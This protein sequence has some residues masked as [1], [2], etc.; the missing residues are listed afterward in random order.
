MG[1]AEKK[2][3]GNKKQRGGVKVFANSVDCLGIFICTVG[4][5]MKRMSLMKNVGY[6][7]ENT[8]NCLVILS[9]GCTKI[10]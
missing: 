9:I 1:L 7:R 3:V 6:A 2:M 8:M 10:P 4:L 5:I